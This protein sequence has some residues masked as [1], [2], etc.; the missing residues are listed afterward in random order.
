MKKDDKKLLEKLGKMKTTL[1]Y[2]K[3]LE[4]INSLV[5]NDWRLDIDSRFLPDSK[6]FTQKEAVEMA[7]VLMKIYQISHGIRCSACN[8]K[9]QI[10]R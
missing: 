7:I 4:D 8:R 1:D 5:D 3:M 6:S 10:K 2:K 9:Y